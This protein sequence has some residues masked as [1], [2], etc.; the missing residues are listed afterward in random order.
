VPPERIDIPSGTTL[1][2]P[3]DLYS[4]SGKDSAG[5]VIIAYGIDGLQDND[6]GPWET[7]I[8]GYAE[9]L[10]KRGFFALIPDYLRKTG[11]KPGPAAAE[12]ML[13]KKEDW[14]AGLLDSVGHARTLSRVDSDRIGLLGFS[15]GGYL[16]LRIRAAAKPRALVEYFAPKLDLEVIAPRGHVPKAQIHHGMKDTVPLTDFSNAGAIEAIL[17]AEGTVVELFPYEGAGHG[18]AGPDEHNK[19]AS[20]LSKERTLK[21]FE[22]NL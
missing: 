9:E 8:R 21:F 15:L 3:A 12:V 18:F 17:K 1:K 19:D 20:D 7:M 5:L 4:P 10:A 2:I 22:T 14:A 11:T 16:T 6:K 13:S